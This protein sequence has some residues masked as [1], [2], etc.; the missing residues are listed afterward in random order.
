LRTFS[1]GMWTSEFKQTPLLPY[2]L[3]QIWER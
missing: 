1:C 2:M 3:P